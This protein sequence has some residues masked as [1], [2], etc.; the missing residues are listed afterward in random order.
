MEPEGVPALLEALFIYNKTDILDKATKAALRL[1][2]KHFKSLID[3]TVVEAEKYSDD[4]NDDLNTLLNTEWHRLKQL[5]IIE[6]GFDQNR[7]TEL[8]SALFV[9]FSRLKTLEIS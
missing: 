4:L 9:K 5:K 2:N 6:R 3:A 7:L 1:C 8:P